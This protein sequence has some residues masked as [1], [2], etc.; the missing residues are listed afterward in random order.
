VLFS[1]IEST[2]LVEAFSFGDVWYEVPV[3]RF[4]TPCPDSS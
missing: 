4:P 2:G 1:E 3:G